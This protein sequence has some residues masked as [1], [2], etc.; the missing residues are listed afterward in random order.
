MNETAKKSGGSEIVRL[1][2]VLGL[3]T[4]ICALLLGVINQ[5][6][7]PLIE[8]NGVNTRNAAMSEIIP[9][10]D[11][12]DL[13]VNLSAE[14]VAAAG[15]TLPAG[16][17]A[18]AINGVYKATKDGQAAGYC[19][20]VQPKGFSGVLT[21]IVGI[22]ADGTVAGIKV[23]AHSETP[24]LGAKAQADADWIGQYVGQQADGQ[25]KVAKDGGTINAIT[26]ATIT[27]RAVTDGVN[28]AAQYV[29]TLG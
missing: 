10:A 7:A 20:Q 29:A 6:T 25:L 4:L 3:I 1:I 27:S 19:L 26:G 2:V 13:N 5:I 28:T 18:S 24:G 11:F 12:E 16:R 14:E 9:D 15:V 23:T 17:T 8:E 22:N 21:M